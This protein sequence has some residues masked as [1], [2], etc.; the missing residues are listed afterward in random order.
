MT[1]SNWMVLIYLWLL[2]AWQKRYLIMTLLVALPIAGTAVGYLRADRYESKMTI[3]VQEAAKH[4]PF[5][6]DFAVETRI[7][8]RINSLD[9]LLHSRHVLE[10][11][12]RELELI[13]ANASAEQRED[14]LN[15][16]SSKLKM[17]LIGSELVELSLRQASREDIVETLRAVAEKF[18]EKIMAP[19]RSSMAGSI[20]FL[21]EQLRQSAKN[22]ASSERALSSFISS[23]ASNLPDLHSGNVRRLADLKI[24]L[25]EK[26]TELAGAKAHMQSLLD[27]LS[28]SNPVVSQIESKIVQATADLAILRARYTERHSAVRTANKELTR[29]ASERNA[30][31]SQAHNITD[32]PFKNLWQAILTSSASDSGLHMLLVSQIEAVQNARARMLDLDRQVKSLHREVSELDAAIAGFGEMEPTLGKLQRKVEVKQEIHTKL[33]KRAEM[34]RVT[35][36]LGKFEAPERVKVIDEPSSPTR[37]IGPSEVVFTAGGLVAAVAMAIA[38]IA[39]S[40]ITN[41]TLRRRDEVETLFGL[42]VITRVPYLPHL[43][44]DAEGLLPD[45]VPRRRKALFWRSKS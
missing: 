2:T 45:E 38:L 9:A 33:M 24:V 20:A 43:G 11:V 16:L 4:N 6:E 22:L 34:A 12:A 42:T 40:E 37:P 8:D 44:F 41:T 26:R 21:D 28:Q 5:L 32:R 17:R 29:L 13:E 19:E 15:R 7:K 1:R 23:N 18:I 27:R 31:L 36:A 25:S 14:Q 3:L 35:G 30:L 39:L 10:S